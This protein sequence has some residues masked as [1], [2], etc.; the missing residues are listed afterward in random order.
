M[1]EMRISEAAKRLS[2]SPQYLRSLE[3]E[4]HIPPVRRDFN[5]RI[6]TLFDIALLKS[7]GVGTRPRRLKSAEEMLERLL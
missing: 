7:M 5:G 6:Y 4:G 1:S 2:V 3:W